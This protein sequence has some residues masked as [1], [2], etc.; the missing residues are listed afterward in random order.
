[1]ETW[2]FKQ[3]TFEF[4]SEIQSIHIKPDIFRI[5]QQSEVAKNNIEALNQICRYASLQVIHTLQIGRQ[6]FELMPHENLEQMDEDLWHAYAKSYV[7]KI[8]NEV[9]VFADQ[10]I[11]SMD[12]DQISKFTQRGLFEIQRIL[13]KFQRKVG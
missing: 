13:K 12:L 1:M 6:I 11:K 9:D 4:Y 3:E 10:L 7:E 8:Q 2:N 5:Y